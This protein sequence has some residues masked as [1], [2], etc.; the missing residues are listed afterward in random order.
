M[1]HYIGFYNE[2]GDIE[3]REP[4]KVFASTEKMNYIASILSKS[5]KVRI[6]S[7][8]F[9]CS[10]GSFEEKNIEKKDFDVI[11]LKTHGDG[12]NNL[13]LKKI[14]EAV[15]E[16]RNYISDHV[17]SDDKIIFYSA[18][19]VWLFLKDILTRYD[20]IL[21]LEE[22]YYFDKPH[23]NP[24]RWVYKSL[25]NGSIATSTKI[26]YVSEA[27]KRKVRKDGIVIYGPFEDYHPNMQRVRSKTDVKIIYT[28]SIDETRGAFI[29]AKAFAQGSEMRMLPKD[30]N[31]EVSFIGYFHGRNAYKQ[32]REFMTIL[33][34]INR[35]GIK[36][37]FK[38]N[39]SGN[40]LR[41]E[42]IKA[43][44]CV[45]P[46]K[47]SS[48]FSEY[49]FPSKLPRYLSYGKL[50]VSSAIKPVMDSSFGDLVIPYY[51]DDTEELIKAITKA[52]E[53]V[54]SGKSCEYENK[55][56]NKIRKMVSEQEE[57][58]IRFLDN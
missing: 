39:L 54:Y 31:I 36:A 57:N 58:L 18:P 23:I 35:N 56:L 27:L 19:S 55:I 51:S 8:G 6:V 38:E 29:L 30:L 15:K 32:K 42:I 52:I 44:I 4:M 45:M 33:D 2:S 3:E 9:S 10:H 47:I 14:L 41:E 49:S 13:S 17:R 37:V 25:E 1:I 46:Q 48:K 40:E 53:L 20:W 24:I 34:S 16:I 21:E 7:P 11:Y 43:D 22:L 12:K 50:V 26:L 5:N 28:G